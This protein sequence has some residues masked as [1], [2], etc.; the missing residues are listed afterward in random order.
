MFVDS[1]RRASLLISVVLAI[2]AAVVVG[3]LLV[4]SAKAEKVELTTARL[5]PNDAGIYVAINTNLASSEWVRAFNLVELLG[6]MDPEAALRRSAETDGDVN[7]EEDIVPFLGGDAGF[8][9]RSFDVGSSDLAGAFIIR[10]TDPR[11]A[12]DVLVEQSELSMVTKEHLSITYYTDDSEGF[13]AAILG[14]HLAVALDDESITDVIEVFAGERESLANVD[15]FQ[16][17]Q[18]E[19]TQNFLGF[20]YINSEILLRNSLD[21]DLLQAAL[22]QAGADIALEPVAAVI[23]ATKDAFVYEMVSVSEPG[24]VSPVLKPRLSRFASAVPADTAIFISSFA[25]A[26]AFLEAQELAE[27]D[28]NAAIRESGYSSIDELFSEAGEELG[29]NSL[30]DLLNLFEGETAFAVWFPGGEQEDAEGLVLSEVGDPMRA[31]EII[32]ALI[33]R[34]QTREALS[35]GDTEVLVISQ[36]DGRKLAFAIDGSDLLIG[37]LGGVTRTLEGNGPVLAS[38]ELYREAVAELSGGLGSYVYFDLQALLGLAEG[39]L[40][41]ELDEAQRA[42]AG[43]IFNM[44]EENGITRASGILTV[45]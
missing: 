11:R 34:S 29:L 21:D 26:K 17:L 32:D 3:G 28:I 37:T 10:T 24:V 2:V 9:L 13:Y 14:D 31:R 6:Q 43:L 35:V 41:P 8:F 44:V 45:K 7:W 25:L 15:D 33:L 16:G 18:S 27:E 40:P 23:T 30:E 12:L 4:F 19:L 1:R 22:A 42:L 38:S 5:V 20:I 39:S 36:D